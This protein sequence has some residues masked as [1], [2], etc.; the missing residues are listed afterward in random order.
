MLNMDELEEI[1][2][3]KLAEL[4]AQQQAL[5][6]QQKQLEAEV[7]LDSILRRLLS[8]EA[9]QRL[10]NVKLINKERYLQAAQVIIY[11]QQSGKLPPKVDD[12]TIKRLL[13]KLSRKSEI[14]IKR[15]SK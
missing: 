2:K 14:K 11:L 3:K 6:D 15:L 12:N 9:M 13:E 10:K 7:Q 8:P 4:Q 1:R 5:D